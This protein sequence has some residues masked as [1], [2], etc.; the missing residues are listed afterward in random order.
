MRPA[1]NLMKGWFLRPKLMKSQRLIGLALAGILFCEP[2]F[3]AVPHVGL[4]DGPFGIRLSPHLGRLTEVHPGS[5]KSQGPDFI[6]IQNLHANRSTQFA[7]SAV[8]AELKAQGFLKGSVAIE[9]ASGPVDLSPMQHYPDPLL[10]K[11]AADEMV[12]R[13]EMSGPIHFA[14]IEGQAKLFGAETRAHYEAHLELYRRTYES[15]E[16]LAQVLSL[17]RKGA[18]KAGSSVDLLALEQLVRYEVSAL[19]L[20]RVLIAAARDVAVLEALFTPAERT[21]LSQAVQ[22]AFSF[23]ALALIRDEELFKNALSLHQKE[24]HSTTFLIT[25]GFHTKGLTQA[26]RAGGFS[27]AVVTPRVRT[28]TKHDE[29]LYV[30]RLMG[31]HRSFHDPK[32]AP[33]E[34]QSLMLEVPIAG[35]IPRFRS[36]VRGLVAKREM[37]LVRRLRPIF[38]A[39][40][41]ATIGCSDIA[42]ESPAPETRVAAQADLTT[43][44]FPRWPVQRVSIVPGEMRGHWMRFDYAPV[45]PGD[46]S[47][48][49]PGRLVSGF[50]G[51]AYQVPPP[52]VHPDSILK[53]RLYAP[54]L[55]PGGVG[56]DSTKYPDLVELARED[57][58]RALNDAEL[59]WR[60]G[61]R[62]I[63]TYNLSQ[64][65][66]S[67]LRLV[68]RIFDWM[69]ETYGIM[70]EDGAYNPTDDEAI[71][72][73]RVMKDSPG[74]LLTS[75][76]NEINFREPEALEARYREIN[77][78]AG[79]IKREDPNHPVSI[80]LARGN[81]SPQV[82][83]WVK[84]MDNIDVV[85]VT[86]YD[87]PAALVGLYAEQLQETFGGKPVG[88]GE[89]GVP[90]TEDP[91]ER[92]N[93]LANQAVQF[94][95]PQ[96]DQPAR[97][98]LAT[99]FEW[100][101]EAWK[102][103]DNV[104]GIVGTPSQGE[105][106]AAF[107]TWAPGPYVVGPSIRQPL[108]AS[109]VLRIPWTGQVLSD[110]AGLAEQIHRMDLERVVDLRRYG[111][112]S[113]HISDGVPGLPFQVQLANPGFFPSD[114][115]GI[116]P[117]LYELQGGPQTI[118]IASSD[119]AGIAP[120]QIESI[121]LRVQGEAIPFVD[122]IS[123]HP[124]SSVGLSPEGAGRRIVLW[125]R[126]LVYDSMAT[127]ARWRTSI[128]LKRPENW[129]GIRNLI[130]RVQEGTPERRIRV[131]ILGPADNPDLSRGRS[132]RIYTLSGQRQLL[133][134]PLSEVEDLDQQNVLRLW[135]EVLPSDA[136]KENPRLNIESVE[137]VPDVVEESRPRDFSFALKAATRG[138][139]ATVLAPF[140]GGALGASPVAPTL[141]PTFLGSLSGSQWAIGVLSALVIAGLVRALLKRWHLGQVVAQWR[142]RWQ[143]A[144]RSE[145]QK[146]GSFLDWMGSPQWLRDR[147]VGE[148]IREQQVRMARRI[149]SAA[150]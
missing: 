39:A 112:I 49:R 30:E 127:P 2:L 90:T 15:Q 20:E 119:F 87:E 55:P 25:G 50:P 16:M 48:N 18:R 95:A 133:W 51:V 142:V 5:Q 62:Y 76:W 57:S 26:A 32:E 70:H 124:D 123:F 6:F 38:W 65:S 60:A 115:A 80:V 84:A 69:Y 9:G 68:R 17:I 134:I 121:L 96:T 63:R 89:F 21:L 52:G 14:V 4:P 136:S 88:I 141:Q 145:Q 31:R 105:L 126:P 104:W 41:L 28:H 135:V 59:L 66:E 110:T 85:L 140:F 131:S 8:L 46:T 149:Q 111:R 93:T 79:L 33:G 129:T 3:A 122:S 128:D 118:H 11:K 98:L 75:G 35:I 106:S 144:A 37:G 146:P 94:I 27:Y 43:D 36:T 19:E 23:Y 77:R 97:T 40:L 78:I 29:W 61:V 102:G 44:N 116:A 67:D 139:L 47:T 108:Q 148:R 74:K 100:R 147:Q 132:S 71:R 42:K 137:L 53:S 81:L 109:Q 22:N 130:L 10:R 73:A 99:A 91:E 56:I 45:V 117:G 114:T 150:A 13:A 72:L 101:A 107:R 120:G 82:V 24:K 64:A 86:V 54:L 1:E 34:I 83:E 125:N 58:T 12:H 138:L 113:L 7:I 103:E 143:E 92:A